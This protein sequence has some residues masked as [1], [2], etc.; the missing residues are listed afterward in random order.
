LLDEIPDVTPLR[1]TALAAL[2]GESVYALVY[3]SDISINYSPLEGN[4]QGANLGVV[5]FE[6]LDVQERTDG[7]SSSLPKVTVRIK[8]P[9][10]TTATTLFLYQNAPAPTSSSEPFDIVPPANPPAIQV[11]P[12]L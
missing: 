9:Q 3:D 8:N 12:A 1:A 11:V 6:V 2:I 5:A 4:L 10:I 7:S